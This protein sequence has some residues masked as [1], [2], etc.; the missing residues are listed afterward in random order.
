[1]ASAIRW[2][3]P[4]R[5][6]QRT[7]DRARRH[8]V[9]PACAPRRRAIHAAAHAE[10]RHHRQRPGF[11]PPHALLDRHTQPRHPRLGLATRHQHPGHRARAAPVCRQG[12]L[13]PPAS[14]MAAGPTA[15]RSMRRAA[16]GSPC[17]KVPSCCASMPK[18]PCSRPCPCPPSAPPC[19]V[20]AATTCGPCSSP[21]AAK[22]VRPRNPQRQPQ[23]GK[24]FMTRTDVQGV[25][26]DFFDD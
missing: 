8:A 26:V 5:L 14:P 11:H 4:G 16:T 17:T 1:M 18:A 22:A 2:A 19:P 10:R 15:P 23:A 3:K 7:Q 20:S 6:A 25:P 9:L 21:L 24:V 13:L 12:R